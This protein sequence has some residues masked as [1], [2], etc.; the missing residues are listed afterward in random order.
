[1]TYHLHDAATGEPLRF[2]CAAAPAA[3][4]PRIQAQPAGKKPP[5]QFASEAAAAA[6]AAYFLPHRKTYTSAAVAT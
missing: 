3:Q 1:M 2:H 5:A 4:S 6:C